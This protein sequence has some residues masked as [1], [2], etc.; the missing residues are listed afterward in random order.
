MRS[1]AAL[2]P[3]LALTSPVLA[4]NPTTSV[5]VE[6]IGGSGS[7]PLVVNQLTGTWPTC[8]SSPP[9]CVQQTAYVS[10][11]LSPFNEEMSI[12]LRGPMVFNAIA[13]YQPDSTGSSYTRV[14]YWSSSGEADNISFLN[15]LGGSASGEWSICQGNSLSWASADATTS[16]ASSTVFGGTLPNGVEMTVLSGQACDSSCEWYRPVGMKGWAGEKI[17]IVEASMPH[18]AGGRSA[19]QGDKPAIWSLNAKIPRTAQYGCNCERT[20]CG[21][22]DMVEVINDGDE[23][24]WTTMYSWQT[25][26]GSPD[27]FVRP[28]GG[29]AMFATHFNVPSSK[30]QV[31]Q[32]ASGQFSYATNIDASLV[33]SWDGVQGT[34]LY[35]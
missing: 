29:A 2:L 24:A 16:E 27:Y 19:S 17:L 33:R 10:G 23:A 15:N 1:L 4:G 35:A 14:S 12:Q 22:F 13:V 6:N 28:T 7:Y 11:N 31:V 20:G 32:L 30:I 5:T 3:L 25:S 21:E 9:S 18:T 8:P 34:T 26:V